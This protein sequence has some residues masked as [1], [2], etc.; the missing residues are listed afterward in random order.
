MGWFQPVN[1]AEA[2]AFNLVTV[3]DFDSVAVDHSNN[4]SGKVGSQNNQWKQQDK[5]NT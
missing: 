4:S 3:Q 5:N 2:N 1:P